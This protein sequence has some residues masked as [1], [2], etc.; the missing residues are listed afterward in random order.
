MVLFHLSRTIQKSLAMIKI[1]ESICA[2]IPSRNT[3]KLFHWEKGNNQSRI[4][5]NIRTAQPVSEHGIGWSYS[6]I[7]ELENS[8]SSMLNSL[9]LV[10]L[11]NWKSHIKWS[12]DVTISRRFNIG[13]SI[14][15]FVS[16]ESRLGASPRSKLNPQDSV[17]CAIV[18]AI[19]ETSTKTWLS[20][21]AQMASFQSLHGLDLTNSQGKHN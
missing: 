20:K 12:G 6:R 13:I 3:S 17:A 9:P 16:I 8:K 14:P 7:E 5:T 18:N 19:G 21:M 10:S 2:N 4:E 15:N 11:E 1:I